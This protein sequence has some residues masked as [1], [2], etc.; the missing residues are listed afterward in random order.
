MD[1]AGSAINTLAGLHDSIVRLTLQVHIQTEDLQAIKG[2]AQAGYSNDQI[3]LIKN[4]HHRRE[5]ALSDALTINAARNV[6]GI[7]KTVLFSVVEEGLDVNTS[8]NRI[9]PSQCRC[10]REYPHSWTSRPDRYQRCYLHKHIPPEE[11]H[12]NN[13]ELLVDLGI[14]R[15][16]VLSVTSQDNGLLSGQEVDSLTVK[17]SKCTI[18]CTHRC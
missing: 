6:D 1:R 7:F 5:V 3:D 18:P 14:N 12:T 13:S 8:S 11:E 16:D 17:N 15:K 10:D 9:P 2:A 4:V